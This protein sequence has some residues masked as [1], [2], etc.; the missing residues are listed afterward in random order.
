MLRL[1]VAIV[2]LLAL[3]EFKVVELVAFGG[4]E[5]GRE[6]DS[7]DHGARLHQP[8]S[9]KTQKTPSPQ[10]LQPSSPEKSPD[11]GS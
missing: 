11:E 9:P 8:D 5:G 10:Q 7:D 1:V 6:G 2:V 3:E 4:R